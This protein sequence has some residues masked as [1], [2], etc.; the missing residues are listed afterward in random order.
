MADAPAP[1]RLEW[2]HR[3]VER[4]GRARE[5]TRARVVADGVELKTLGAGVADEA[6]GREFVIGLVGDGGDRRVCVRAEELAA[7]TPAVGDLPR[8]VISTFWEDD[9]RSGVQRYRL[10]TAIAAAFDEARSLRLVGRHESREIM[11]RV[12][13]AL[14]RV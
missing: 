2:R 7:W 5:V 1:Y 4:D 8:G 10:L 13:G 12:R 11:R 14:L 9:E 6:V 3:S